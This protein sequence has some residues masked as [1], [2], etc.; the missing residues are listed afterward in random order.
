VDEDGAI[1]EEHESL[2]NIVVRGDNVI[3]LNLA[4]K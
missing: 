1:K 3:F 4:N 2:G